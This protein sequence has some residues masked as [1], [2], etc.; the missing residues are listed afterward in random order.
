MSLWLNYLAYDIM[1][2]VVFG[3]GFNMLTETS[4]RYILPLIDSMVFSMLLVCLQTLPHL[5]LFV[6]A[7]PH[8]YRAESFLHCISLV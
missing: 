7:G 1:G 6:T 5:A 4:L 2:E 3:Q 8:M